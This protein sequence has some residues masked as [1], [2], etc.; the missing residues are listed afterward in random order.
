MFT[1]YHFEIYDHEYTFYLI[2][3]PSWILAKFGSFP[4]AKV[5]KLLTV[6]S[7]HISRPKFNEKLNKAI[8]LNLGDFYGFNYW[9]KRGDNKGNL[10]EYYPSSP[11]ITPPCIVGVVV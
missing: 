5:G 8:L 1:I 11:H 4:C 6:A 2:W 3:R 10:M 7:R 9:T